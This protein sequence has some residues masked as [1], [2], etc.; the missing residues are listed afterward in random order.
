MVVPGAEK[1][2]DLEAVDERNLPIPPRLRLVGDVLT[3]LGQVRRNLDQPLAAGHEA[4]LQLR[5]PVLRRVKGS[6]ALRGH[7]HSLI[8]RD[9]FAD[10]P[11]V[12]PRWTGT[13]ASSAGSSAAK[14]SSAGT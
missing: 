1:P 2:S 9:S 5:C 14:P 3:R 12:G 7:G 11:G 10:G 13:G 4:P 6:D 8:T